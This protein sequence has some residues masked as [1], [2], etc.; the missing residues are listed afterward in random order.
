M[1]IV[2]L[3][4]SF[5][6]RSFEGFQAGDL[7]L[8]LA[9]ALDQLPPE[10]DRAPIDDLD[11]RT[12]AEAHAEPEQS[13]NLSNYLRIN[14]D[15]F[16]K[17]SLVIN[18]L[19]RGN[20]FQSCGRRVRSSWPWNFRRR[21]GRWRCPTKGKCIVDI[22]SNDFFKNTNENNLFVGVVLVGRRSP[23]GLFGIRGVFPSAVSVHVRDVVWIL[24]A[25]F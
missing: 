11:E 6:A 2:I 20:R 4:V 21:N 8:P 15:D 16:Y 23:N 14:V 22:Y 13:A 5:H 9:L 7:V 19:V 25:F 3:H 10:P 24:I 1:L 17:I 12:Q 18:S